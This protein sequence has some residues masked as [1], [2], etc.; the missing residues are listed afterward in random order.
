VR[1]LL[2]GHQP[3]AAAV[4][5]LHEAYA[6]LFNGGAPADL[7]AKGASAQQMERLLDSGNY[8]SWQREYLR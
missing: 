1:V 5:A 2:Q 8:R 4:R 3:V 7:E 6:H